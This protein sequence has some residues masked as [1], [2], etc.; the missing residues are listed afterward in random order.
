[1]KFI[2]V[3]SGI[4]AF[5]AV[6]LGA[7]GSHAFKNILETT[8]KLSQYQTAT[9]YQWYHTIGLMVLA[10][11]FHLTGKSE[12][13][14]SAYFMIVG[15]ILFSGSLYI[16]SLSTVKLFAHIT[17][18]GGISFLVAWGIMIFGIIRNL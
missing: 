12:F 15:I 8:G 7:I 10:W 9:E 6:A 18:L 1:M 2:L 11:L 17:P 5:L 13:V 4:S 16:Y 14:Y 3:I